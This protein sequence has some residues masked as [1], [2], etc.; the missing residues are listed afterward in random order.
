M[1]H[2]KPEEKTDFNKRG[3][4]LSSAVGDG[5]DRKAGN[6]LQRQISP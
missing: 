1:F 2:V 6:R 4:H 5:H 3:R